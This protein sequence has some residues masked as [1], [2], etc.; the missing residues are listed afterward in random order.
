MSSQEFFDRLCKLLCELNKLVKEYLFGK[1]IECDG[2]CGLSREG[3]GG[4]VK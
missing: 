4:K 1:A 2:E 3:Y